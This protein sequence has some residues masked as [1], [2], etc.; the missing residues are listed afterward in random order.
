M[1]DGAAFCI[2]GGL[3]Q[4]K[5]RQKRRGQS[6]LPERFREQI[7]ALLRAEGQQEMKSRDGLLCLAEPGQLRLLENVQQRLKPRL[8]V[9]SHPRDM[10]LKVAA[11]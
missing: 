9:L 2:Y 4:V 10:P 3:A 1:H 6:R 8:I 7:S 11:V 5:L